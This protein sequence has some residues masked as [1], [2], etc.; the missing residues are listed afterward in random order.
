MDVPVTVKKGGT[1]SRSH[2]RELC[3]GFGSSS[4]F[5]SLHRSSSAAEMRPRPAPSWRQSNSR[6]RRL[7]QGGLIAGLTTWLLVAF[8]ATPWDRAGSQARGGSG[9][10]GPTLGCTG[11]AQ[12]IEGKFYLPHGPHSPPAVSNQPSPRALGA[13]SKPRTYA[14]A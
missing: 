4:S 12:Q 8:V 10:A 1:H 11:L 14:A 13:A 2:S 5:S 3:H 6:V 9:A 7:A